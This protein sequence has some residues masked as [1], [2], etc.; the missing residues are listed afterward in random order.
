MA[1]TILRATTLHAEP[2]GMV[3]KEEEASLDFSHF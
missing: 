3:S 1:L 2:Y